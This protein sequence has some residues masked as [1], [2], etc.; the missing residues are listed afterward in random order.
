MKGIL[1]EGRKE[2]RKLLRKIPRYAVQ[3]GVLYRRGF[4]APLLRCVNKAEPR[5]FLR[6]SIREAAVIIVGGKPSLWR[7]YGLD[8]FGRPYAY[9]FV[10][11]C[12][13]CHRFAMVS[14]ALSFKITQMVSPWPFTI[15]GIDLIGELP[16]AQ[17]WAKYAIVVVDY[18]TKWVE[19]K[20][21][22]TITSAKV[23]SFMVK[24]IIYRYKVPMKI[25]SNNETRFESVEFIEFCSLYDIQKCFSAIAHPQANNQVEVVNKVIK[26][27]IKKRL[28]RDKGSW[29]DGLPLALWSYQTTETTTMGTHYFS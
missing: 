13:R 1:P 28:Q 21:L 9:K 7:L 8:I 26:S 11:N 22:A 29:V 5:K 14:R 15:R 12:D 23:I 17:G 27:I 25:I 24:N 10:K 18:F 4:S 20:S 3:D 6:M 16:M 2:A 19:A